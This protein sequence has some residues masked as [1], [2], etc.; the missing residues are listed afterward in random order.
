[1]I[2]KSLRWDEIQI[3][4]AYRH[5][6]KTSV[7]RCIRW[8]LRNIESYK[9]WLLTRKFNR[10][11]VSMKRARKELLLQGFVPISKFPMRTKTGNFAYITSNSLLKGE[12]LIYPEH[13]AHG[14][15]PKTGCRYRDIHE[16][17]GHVGVEGYTQIFY[18]DYKNG[19]AK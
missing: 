15:M 16:V 1:M 6:F 5:L 9:E 4:L 10:P 7:K 13:F 19:V 17:Y 2:M 18:T 8:T 12:R 3:A 11:P 14:Y